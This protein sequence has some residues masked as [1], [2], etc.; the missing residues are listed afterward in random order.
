MLPICGI[1]Q[2]GERN[3]F[4]SSMGPLDSTISRQLRAFLILPAGL[5][6]PLRNK[7]KPILFN[8]LRSNRECQ[9]IPYTLYGVQF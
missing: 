1:H 8:G 6:I 5:A 7:D 3:R 9:Y 2:T 4:G